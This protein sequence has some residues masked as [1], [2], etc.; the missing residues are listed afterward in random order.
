MTA[1]PPVYIDFCDFGTHL[2]KADNHWTRILAP[3]YDVKIVDKPDL[4]FHSHDGNVHRLYTCK[5]VFHTGESYWPDLTVSDYSFTFHEMDDPHNLRLPLYTRVESELLVKAEGEAESVL[6]G[7]TG[8]CCFFT[9]YGNKKTTL[10]LDFFHRLSRYRKVDSAGKYL[11]NIGRS[12]PFGIDSKLAF[13]RSYKFYMAFENESMPGYTTEKIAEAMAARCLPI[14]W[15]NPEVAKDFNPKSFLNYHDF[16]NEEAL[17]DRIIEIDRDDSLYL[18]YLKEPF[19]YGN[20]PNIFY[21]RGRML[22]FLVGA[23]EDPHPPVGA[24]RRWYQ[25]GRWMLLK[26]NK[27]HRIFP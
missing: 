13:M 17:I 19:F 4:L 8:F 22:D 2:N 1:K 27:P 21:D 15:G 20:K 5:K 24:R 3:K 26:R 7:K 12:V 6:K 14:Y 18:Q 10:R 16:P 23:I 25:P 11:N 9:S